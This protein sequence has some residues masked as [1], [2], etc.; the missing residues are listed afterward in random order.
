MNPRITATTTTTEPYS[1]STPTISGT[2]YLLSCPLLLLLLLHL[3]R[4]QMYSPKSPISIAN[5]LALALEL[6]ALVSLSHCLPTP[7]TL[8]HCKTFYFLYMTCLVPE[9]IVVSHLRISNCFI[10]DWF[11]FAFMYWNVLMW[12]EFLIGSYKV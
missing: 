8:L 7:S 11:W 1:H 9:K 5:P 4:P 2:E 3:H 10:E 12:K 6:T